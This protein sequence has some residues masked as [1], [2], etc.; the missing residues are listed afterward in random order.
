M[1]AGSNWTLSLSEVNP[2]GIMGI[3]Q[4]LTIDATGR[5]VGASD[6][7]HAPLDSPAFTGT[8]TTPTPS[9]GN[10]S[11]QIANTQFVST[12]VNTTVAT[13][14]AALP[15][16]PP[17]P[18]NYILAYS[19]LGLIGVSRIW[20]GNAVTDATGAWSV[21]YSNAGFTATPTVTVS[22]LGNGS[23]ITNSLLC[24]VNASSSTAASGLALSI[25]SILGALGLAT[26][27]AGITVQVTAFG[28]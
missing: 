18:A 23:L 10:N 3:F 21:S 5:I 11:A 20:G 26:A 24:F 25:T 12:T 9:N 8:P 2:P 4:G 27:S 6:L 15:T 22:G 13:A 28:W 17:V 16:I 1:A 7:H 14:I 19:P